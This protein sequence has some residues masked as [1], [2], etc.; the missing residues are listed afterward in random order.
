VPDEEEVAVVAD[1]A[2]V[3]AARTR[4]APDVVAPTNKVNVALPSSH[5]HVEES[6]KDLAELSAIRADLAAVVEEIAP[7][8]KVKRLRER[9]QVSTTRFR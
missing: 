6:S 4:T 1:D 3:T 7:G 2:E 5:L 8:P 9:A